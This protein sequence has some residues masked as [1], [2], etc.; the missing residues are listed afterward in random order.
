MSPRPWGPRGF[1]GILYLKGMCK[2]GEK[3]TVNNRNKEKGVLGDV[4][5]ILTGRRDI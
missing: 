5:L 2:R 1:G 4:V 3:K